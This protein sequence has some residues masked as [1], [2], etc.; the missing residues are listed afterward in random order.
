MDLGLYNVII[1]FL[2][3]LLSA[4]VSKYQQFGIEVAIII[5]GVRCWIQLT[6]LSFILSDLFRAHNAW[7]VALMSTVLILLGAM[8]GV[9][10]RSKLGYRGM[11]PVYLISL[12]VPL[13]VGLLGVRFAVNTDEVWWEP[14]KLIPI[15]GMLIGNAISGLSI[16][17]GNVLSQVMQN[18]DQI[19]LFLSFGADR[20]EAM[21]PILVDAIRTAV[22]PSINS[23]SVVGTH[24]Y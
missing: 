21:R 22:M 17:T 18:G 6:L 1:A 4:L 7:L 2:F 20:H 24:P 16:G 5:A 19:E 12:C 8:E 3:L 9:I 14:R 11:Y 10:Q 15:L 23:M 13:V